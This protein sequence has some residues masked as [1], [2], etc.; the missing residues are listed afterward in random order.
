MLRPTH[1]CQQMNVVYD[2]LDTLNP[3]PAQIMAL[4]DEAAS[5]ESRG[6]EEAVLFIHQLQ[7][8]VRRRLQR[9]EH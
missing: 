6:D 8:H 4:Y 5:R 3:S 9:Q 7:E 2:I 1:E